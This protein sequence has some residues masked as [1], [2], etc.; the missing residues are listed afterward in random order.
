MKDFNKEQTNVNLSCGGIAFFA[1]MTL[2]VFISLI[3]QSLLYAFGITDGALFYAVC[4]TFSIIAIAAAFFL[5]RFFCKKKSAGNFYIKKCDPLYFVFAVIL[6][7]GMMFGL[8]FVNGIIADIMSKFGL[9]VGGVNP[10]LYNI[11]L[12]IL[13]SVLLAV[14]PAV[15]E[16][17]FFRGLMLDNVLCGKNRGSYAIKAVLSVS[18]CFALYHGSLTQFFYQLIYG[19]F[20]ALLT[21]KSGSV[22]PAIT[23]HF[24]NNFIVLVFGFFEI[25][26]D[27]NNP[28]FIAAGIAL[29]VLFVVF[30]TIYGKDK[31]KNA[32]QT[33][34]DEKSVAPL[35][36]FWLPYGVLGA[37]VC[38]ALIIGSAVAV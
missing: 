5:S 25:N 13:F 18:L 2:Y 32:L 22:L 35:K 30:I 16:E 36:L 15:A 11:G 12:F 1:M 33:D 23:A 28:F 21:L 14:F 8:G 10:P 29:L 3:G 38:A 19:L 9:N 17:I 6:A 7:V 24:L 31:N 37:A 26:V 27:L 4:S 34:V 20:L